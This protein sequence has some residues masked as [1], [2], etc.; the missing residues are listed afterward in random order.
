MKFL[1]QAKDYQGGDVN[2]VLE[3]A[4]MQIAQ[5]IF[6]ERGVILLKIKELHPRNTRQFLLGLTHRVTAKQLVIFSRQLAVLISSNV[7]I[8]R[9]LRILAKQTPSP[10]FQS[11]IMSVADEVDG[12]ARLSAAMH[13]YRRIFDDF[14]IY[15]VRAGETTGTLDEVLTY[16]A[17]QKEKDYELNSRIL[18]SMIYPAFVIS[19]LIIMMFLMLIFVLPKLLDIVAS[20]GA[21]LPFTTRMLLA[22]S[23]FSRDYW[24]VLLVVVLAIIIGLVFLRRTVR[25]RRIFD[26]ITLHIPVIGKIFIKMYLARLARSLSNLISSGVPINRSLEITADVVGN[27]VYKELLLAAKKNIET[28]VTISESLSATKYIPP[29]M[30]QMI[31]IGEETGKLDKI[32]QKVSQFYTREVDSLTNTLAGLIEPLVIVLIGIGAAIVVSGILL[33]IYSISGAI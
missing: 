28:G 29:M 9:A 12:G 23:G 6:K 10:Y 27:R 3:A 25:G 19:V 22:L 7:A 5:N 11:V 20:S 13:K 14:F 15:M 18:I 21:T 33:P 26:K 4:N 16:L 31:V 2:G 24:L 8:V 17:D 30:R 1:Y 32:L